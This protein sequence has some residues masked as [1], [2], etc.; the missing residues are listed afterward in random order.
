MGRHYQAALLRV[1]LGGIATG[2][3]PTAIANMTAV[4][5]TQGPAPT[6][7]INLLLVIA[8]FVTAA[9]ALLI[10]FALTL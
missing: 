6:A 1:G 4:T 9:N 7:F 2:P 3:I 5:K 8:F 10:C